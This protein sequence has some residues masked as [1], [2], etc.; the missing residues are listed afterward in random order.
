MNYTNLIGEVPKC[1]ISTVDLRCKP[2]IGF[3]IRS[4]YDV[5]R[6]SIP[7]KYNPIYVKDT[8]GQIYYGVQG[9]FSLGGV[10]FYDDLLQLDNTNTSNIIR[11][12]DQWN[13]NICE[14]YRYTANN[15][16]SLEFSDN[17]NILEDRYKNL[18]IISYNNSNAPSYIKVSGMYIFIFLP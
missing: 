16:V 9:H 14:S 3:P 17:K 8:A 10:Q 7:E 11:V 15:V 6:H 4:Q 2:F 18:D 5:E 1:K 12:L 13:I